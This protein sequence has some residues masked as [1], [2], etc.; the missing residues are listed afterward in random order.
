[1]NLYSKECGMDFPSLV[2]NDF[3]LSPDIASKSDKQGSLVS[4]TT[5]DSVAF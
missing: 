3:A 4:S 2:P 1:M 5:S